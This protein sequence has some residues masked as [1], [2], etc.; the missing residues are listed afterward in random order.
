MKRPLLLVWAFL[1]LLGLWG[2]LGMKTISSS[3]PRSACRAC[4]NERRKLSRLSKADVMSLFQNDFVVYDRK[5]QLLCSICVNGIS[6]ESF[7]FTR[8]ATMGDVK[9][10]VCQEMVPENSPKSSS[11]SSSDMA[12]ESQ[13]GHK[14]HLPRT[15]DGTFQ[16]KPK[17]NVCQS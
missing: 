2:F 7:N 4:G 14:R 15:E 17:A 8:E 13:T 9:K 11:S 5:H 16:K 12:D 10:F 3:V 6:P 1:C